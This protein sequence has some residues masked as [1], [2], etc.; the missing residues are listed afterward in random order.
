MI[1]YLDSSALVKRYTREGRAPLAA[2]HPGFPVR[3][4]G[5]RLVSEE[6]RHRHVRAS[7]WPGA[8]PGRYRGKKRPV[9]WA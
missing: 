6:K 9:L 2:D 8:G 4:P 3:Q 7:S 1:L 5:R